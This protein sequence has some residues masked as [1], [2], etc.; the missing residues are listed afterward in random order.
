[1]TQELAFKCPVS[2]PSKWGNSECPL[3]FPQS[4]PKRTALVAHPV[5]E[6]A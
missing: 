3:L 2:F 1:M 4:F 6:E 5:E